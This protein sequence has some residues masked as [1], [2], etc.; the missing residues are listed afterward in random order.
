VLEIECRDAALALEHLD[1]F[2]DVI[3]AALFG[4]HLHA[5]V[6]APEIAQS[7]HHHLEA[8][9]F[10]PVKVRPAPP[11]LEDVFIHSIREAEE[12]MKQ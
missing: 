9:G 12:G 7:I 6:T 1:D 8:E 4:N 11:S 10:A 2:P 3:D 5:V